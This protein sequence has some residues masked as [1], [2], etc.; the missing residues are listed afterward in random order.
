MRPYFDTHSAGVLLLIVILA[1]LGLEA[2]QFARQ[3]RWRADATRIGRR[4]FW[5]GFGACL[6]VTNSALYLGPSAFPAALYR[7]VTNRVRVSAL[8]LPTSSTP[9]SFPL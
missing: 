3:W 4:S 6:I 7:P 9:C 2:V 8:Y 5:L 1:W